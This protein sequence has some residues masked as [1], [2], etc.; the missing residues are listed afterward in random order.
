MASLICFKDSRDNFDLACFGT[1][2]DDI[3][4]FLSFGAGIVKMM[5]ARH[6]CVVDIG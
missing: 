1:P 4:L 5:A 6:C 2:T 3:L